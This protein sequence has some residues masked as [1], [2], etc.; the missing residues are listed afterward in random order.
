MRWDPLES[1]KATC[2]TT[3]RDWLARRRWDDLDAAIERAIADVEQPGVRS[4]LPDEGSFRCV[5]D[6]RGAYAYWD[7]PTDT[8]TVSRNL[9]TVEGHVSEDDELPVVDRENDPPIASVW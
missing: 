5:I 2:E 8:I 7:L 3:I 1:V 6:Y 9:E 4:T